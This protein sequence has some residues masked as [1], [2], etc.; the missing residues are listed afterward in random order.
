[1]VRI[2][3][4]LLLLTKL[5]FSQQIDYQV[6][7]N[8]QELMLL[9]DANLISISAYK[10]IK[11]YRF[12]NGDIKSFYELIRLGL[13]PSQIRLIKENCFISQ[14]E[15][16][17]S[18]NSIYDE[19]IDQRVSLSNLGLQFRSRINEEE[20]KIYF[21]T[22]LGDGRLFFGNVQN[23][24]RDYFM[25]VENEIGI[26]PDWNTNRLGLLF[27]SNKTSY[28]SVFGLIRSDTTLNPFLRFRKHFNRWSIDSRVQV[29]DVIEHNYQLW[30]SYSNL[31]FR[32]SALVVD[33]Q[34]TKR[35]LNIQFSPSYNHLLLLEKSQHSDAVRLR[36]RHYLKFNRINSFYE[37][38]NEKGS[39]QDDW[40]IK[41]GYKQRFNQYAY[42]AWASGNTN[43]VK[44]RWQGKFI[45]D[46]MALKHIAQVNCSEGYNVIG[47]GS[48]SFNMLSLDLD[49]G[50]YRSFANNENSYSVYGIGLKEQ[51]NTIRLE[52]NQVLTRCSIAKKV[53]SNLLSLVFDLLHNVEGEES[54]GS[55]KL[56]LIQAF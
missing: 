49:V 44:V 26:L 34:V 37:L 43:D 42:Q 53:E 56:Q 19:H 13:A 50:I 40:S 16:H 31:Q 5:S 36:F 27:A 21:V 10:V 54:K 35:S 18:L 2:V 29:S 11:E 30:Y 7:L 45:F 20:K 51:I 46:D 41:L 4:A 33:D 12:K 52:G 17:G 9:V 15:W 39:E 1:M 28:S 6:D 38:V 32:F 48:V 14:S 24:L 23:P 22:D 3:I 55:F 8:S 47:G 25:N